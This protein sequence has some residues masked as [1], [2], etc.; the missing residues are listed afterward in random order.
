[1]AKVDVGQRVRGPLGFLPYSTAP[2]PLTAKNSLARLTTTN[3]GPLDYDAQGMMPYLGVFG[4]LFLFFIS[5]YIFIRNR[6]YGA[7]TTTD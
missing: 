6:H 3:S 1:V 7:L 4:F 2:P 5:N